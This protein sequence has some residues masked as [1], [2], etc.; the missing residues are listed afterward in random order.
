ME[1]IVEMALYSNILAPFFGKDVSKNLL[2][3]IKNLEFK[4][5]NLTH[6]FNVRLE[7]LVLVLE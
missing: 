3:N 1:N 6:D 5:L 7:P 2:Q 4:N